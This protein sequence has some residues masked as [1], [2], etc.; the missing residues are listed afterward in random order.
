MQEAARQTPSPSRQVGLNAAARLEALSPD[1]RTI[2]RALLPAPLQDILTALYSN[3]A[4]LTTE[5]LR[6]AMELLLEQADGVMNALFAF[7]LID[8]LVRDVADHSLAVGDAEAATAIEEGYEGTIT[9]LTAH[10]NLG[11]IDSLTRADALGWLRGQMRAYRRARWPHSTVSVPLGQT[12]APISQ[13]PPSPAQTTATVPVSVTL[14]ERLNQFL[15]RLSPSVSIVTTAMTLTL[16]VAGGLFL[17]PAGGGWS[18]VI[19]LMGLCAATTVLAS[20]FR[21]SLTGIASDA[22]ADYSLEEEMAPPTMQPPLPR[23][24]AEELPLS[25]EA[26]AIARELEVQGVTIVDLN[27]EQ[28][29][30]MIEETAVEM[31]R[32]VDIARSLCAETAP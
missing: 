12:N 25:P 5:D 17:S 24:P 9:Q 7:R 15:P 3:R 1:L 6:Q 31:A 21:A 2:V 28:I 29:V 8:D 11:A 13:T 20:P 19:V 27:E 4:A 10:F 23:P 22:E 26:V 18:F 32:L 16:P 14:A 30:T